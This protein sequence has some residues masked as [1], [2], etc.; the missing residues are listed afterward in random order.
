MAAPAKRTKQAVEATIQKLNLKSPPPAD[1]EAKRRVVREFAGLDQALR[2]RRLEESAEEPARAFRRQFYTWLL[3]GR[4]SP[5]KMWSLA[6]VEA[7]PLLSDRERRLWLQFKRPAERAQY[8]LARLNHRVDAL[9]KLMG[10]ASD[11]DSAVTRHRGV[12]TP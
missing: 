9:L 4:R 11:I 5:T 12:H 3:S 1:E 7:S 8:V 10:V 2:D 6:E